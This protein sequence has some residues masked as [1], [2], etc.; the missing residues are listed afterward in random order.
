MRGEAEAG[1]EFTA[2]GTRIAASP[3]SQP[4]LS[5]RFNKASEELIQINFNIYLQKISISNC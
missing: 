5:T 4:N 3:A 1:S 2:K